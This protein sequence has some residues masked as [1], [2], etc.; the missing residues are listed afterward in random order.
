MD[1]VRLWVDDSHV[2][3]GFRAFVVEGIGRKWARLVEA[4]TG[5]RITVPKQDMRHARPVPAP[6]W[7]RIARQLRRNGQRNL[8]K[9]VA[10]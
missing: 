8:A 4:S 7:R 9:A 6:R 3:C 10:Q 2:G 5:T 1:Y